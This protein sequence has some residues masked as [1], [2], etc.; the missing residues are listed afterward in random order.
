M[1][2]CKFAVE[3]LAVAA[4]SP[5]ALRDWYVGVLNAVEKVRL[6]DS[7]PA[8]MIELPGGLLVEI[9][10]AESSLGDTSRNSLAGWRH[11]ALSV[12]NIESARDALAGAGV[13]FDD[14]IKPA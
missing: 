8:F 3:H 4:K 2:S 10:Q 5:V 6:N 9:Y 14:P 13:P 12:E 1:S 11:L 7:P